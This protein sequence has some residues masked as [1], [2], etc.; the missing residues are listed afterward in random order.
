MTTMPSHTDHPERPGLTDGVAS[1]FAVF[2]TIKPGHA[3]QLRQ[4]L[5]Q[6]STAYRAER[7][8][9]REI[10]TLHDARHVIFD[11]DTRFMFASVFDGSWDTYIDDFAATIV[12]EHFGKIFSHSEG[13][14][15]VTDPNVKDWF[16][17]HQ[18]PALIFA[19]S[20]PDLTV[21]Q[22]W[23]DQRVDSAFQAVLDTP[24]FRAALDNPANAALVATP[25]FK[26][27][28]DEASG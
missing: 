9:L 1:E 4:D 10:G 6:I 11:D 17:A 23:K 19:S 7:S 14:P 8:A 24:E 18:A 26:R 27:L 25:A 2:T 28:L 13:F 16:V 15:G 22:I 12:G 21:K 5:A 3:D 20:Y